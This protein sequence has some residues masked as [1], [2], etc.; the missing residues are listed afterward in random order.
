VFENRREPILPTRIFI[1]RLLRCLG[2]ALAIIAVALSIGVAGY[3]FIAGLPWID[4]LLNAS[5][6]LTG[7]GPVNVLR[8][9]AAKVFASFYALFSGVVFIS[10][11]GLLLSPIA[12]RVLH[13][14]HLS[15]EDMND[16][17]SRKA[18][19]SKAKD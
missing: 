13:K 19:D 6:I 15:D 3:H 17:K 7:M 9:N 12:H 8:S 11:M 4:A 10:L 1:R 14:F 2:L 5:M 18:T 16:K